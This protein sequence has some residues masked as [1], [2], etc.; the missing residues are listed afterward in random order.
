MLQK[1]GV[2]NI[3]GRVAVSPLSCEYLSIKVEQSARVVWSIGQPQHRTQP[4]LAEKGGR[5]AGRERERGREG[6]R[7]RLGLLLLS[8]CSAALLAVSYNLL[9]TTKHLKTE[10][11]ASLYVYDVKEAIQHTQTLLWIDIDTSHCCCSCTQ[12]GRTKPHHR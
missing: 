5:G 1:T 3:S 6:G 11:C 12:S 10:N 8:S 4:R 9:I 2:A 7:V